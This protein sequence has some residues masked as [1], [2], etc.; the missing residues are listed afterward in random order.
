MLSVAA[1]TSGRTTPVVQ[2]IEKMDVSDTVGSQAK[3]KAVPP[4]KENLREVVIDGVLFVADTRGNK[5]VR[6]SSVLLLLL[7][8]AGPSTDFCISHS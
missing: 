5:L 6:Q 2:A 4:P 3:G 7:S 8:R 1:S